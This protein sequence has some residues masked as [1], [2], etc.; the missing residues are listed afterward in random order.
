MGADEVA[1]PHATGVTAE[2]KL[3]FQLRPGES[4]EAWIRRIRDGL[5]EAVEERRRE[6]PED[7]TDYSLLPGTAEWWLRALT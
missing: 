6:H 5:L 2:G 1:R 3:Y 4:S 7:A